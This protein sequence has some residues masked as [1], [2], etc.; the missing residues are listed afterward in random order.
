MATSPTEERGEERE[1][2][3]TE[4][5]KERGAD[6]CLSYAMCVE[7]VPVAERLEPKIQGEAAHEPKQ[8]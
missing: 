1:D 7:R 3:V 6:C 2:N 4:R 8:P 5:E